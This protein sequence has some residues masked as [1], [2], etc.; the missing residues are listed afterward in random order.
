M[1]NMPG[2]R[3]SILNTIFAGMVI[4]RMMG[5]LTA[6]PLSSIWNILFC[7]HLFAYYYISEK[8]PY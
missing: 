7:V 8:Y 1:L 4:C 3:D 5:S 6:K 2:P